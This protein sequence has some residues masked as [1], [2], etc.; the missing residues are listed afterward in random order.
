MM[1]DVRSTTTYV[2]NR[3]TASLMEQTTESSRDPHVDQKRHL[4]GSGLLGVI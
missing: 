4:W 3:Y 1:Y 2:Q